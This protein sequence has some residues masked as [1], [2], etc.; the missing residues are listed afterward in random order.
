MQLGRIGPRLARRGRHVDDDALLFSLNRGGQVRHDRVIDLTDVT[1]R[2]LERLLPRIEPSQSQQVRHQPLH[3]GALPPDDLDESLRVLALTGLVAQRFQ[4]SADGRQRR[5]Q[6]VRDIRHEITAD[7]IRPPQVG[8][9]VKHQHRSAGAAGRDR[10]GASDEYTPW[11]AGEDQV[12]RRRVLA[13]QRGRQLGGDIGMPDHFEVRTSDCRCIDVQHGLRR[14]VGEL[15]PPAAIDEH[16]TLHHSRQDRVHPRAIAR[17]LLDAASQL[18]HRR[19]EDARD[20][21]EL[22]AAIVV[23]RLRQIACRIPAR[24]GRNRAHAPSERGRYEPRDRQRH[25]NRDAERHERHRPDG[26]QLRVDFGERK[27][28]PDVTDDGMRR[29]DRDVEHVSAHRRAVSLADAGAVAA[30]CQHLGPR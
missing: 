20:I 4:V 23:R 21:A 18:L 6:L 2:A 13:P 22:V 3:S 5:A 15:Q 27:G 11:I 9:V 12:P 30:G 28:E 24:H 17:Q 19:V 29:A 25:R 14:V 10:R 8:D 16:H 7:L 26:G 1:S